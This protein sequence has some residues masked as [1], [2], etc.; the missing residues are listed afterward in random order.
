[1]YDFDVAMNFMLP[2]LPLNQ[3]HGFRSPRPVGTKTSFLFDDVQRFQRAAAWRCGNA[4][5][6]R[7]DFFSASL[8]LSLSLPDAGIIHDIE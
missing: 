5:G 6:W 7:P 1:M 8:S 3:L 2:R 4:T